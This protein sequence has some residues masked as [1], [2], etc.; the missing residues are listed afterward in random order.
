MFGP[1]G[2]VSPPDIGFIVFSDD[3]GEHPS[4]S[5][6]LFRHIVERHPVLWVNTIGMRNPTLSL[7]DL[8][9]VWRKASRMLG[10]GRAPAATPEKHAPLPA[11]L[12]VCQPFMLPFSSSGFVRRFNRRSVLRAV[13]DAANEFMPARC[14]V[15]ST[16]PN[17]CDYVD[18]FKAER[19]VYYCVDD[20]S[21]WPGL[22]HDLVRNMERQLIDKSDVLVATSRNLQSKLAGYGLPL[23]LLNHG[24]DLDLFSVEPDHVHPS[25]AVIPAPRAGYFGLIDERSDQRLLSQLADRMPD[26]SFVFTGPVA[27]SVDELARKPNVHFT[28]AVPYAQLPSIV[29]GL[30]VL[31]LPYVVNDFTASISPLKL[32]EYLAT[33]R[34]VICT[35]MAEALHQQPYVTIADGV[36]AWV[37]AVRAGLSA[38]IDQRRQQAKQLLAGESWREKAATFAALCAGAA[39]VASAQGAVAE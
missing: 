13:S 23:H 6:H 19:V 33:G 32:K 22:E 29:K 15:V 1:A 34:P 16:V 35:P 17:A 26:V 11:L 4:S 3:W 38:D 30:S 39:G 25:L 2:S 21:Q 5:Q 24:V 27:T 10:A 7:A 36:E 8:R 12:R 28:G 18:A 37:A 9:K 14:V 20:F 31:M